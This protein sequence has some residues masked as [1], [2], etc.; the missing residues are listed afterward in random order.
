MDGLFRVTSDGNEVTSQ[1]T[2]PAPGLGL[3]AGGWHDLEAVAELVDYP[4]RL[5][6]LTFKVAWTPRLRGR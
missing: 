2:R 4:E 3:R 1:T 5:R 6:Y